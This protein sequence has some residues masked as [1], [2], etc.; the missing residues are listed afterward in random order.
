MFGTSEVA[1]RSWLTENF[2]VESLKGTHPDDAAGVLESLKGMEDYVP[3]DEDDPFAE[4]D[5][6]PKAA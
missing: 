4:P 5:E 1:Y 2:G 3:G 6:L